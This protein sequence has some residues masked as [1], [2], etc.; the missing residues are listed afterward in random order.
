MRFV[1]EE[2]LPRGYTRLEY[3]ES[4]GT[5]FIDTGVIGIDNTEFVAAY[6]VQLNENNLGSIAG[7]SDGTNAIDFGKYVFAE[8]LT[9]TVP[10]LSYLTNTWDCT[11]AALGD[12]SPIEVVV[13]F[14]DGSQLAVF[15]EEYTLGV[16][17]FEGTPNV[18]KNI[19]LFKVNNDNTDGFTG[20][21]FYF[22]LYSG[23]DEL[24]RNFIPALRKSDNKPGMYDTITNTFYTNAGINEFLYETPQ[25][26]QVEYI[27]NTKYW[28][29]EYIEADGASYI[30]TGVSLKDIYGFKVKYN[31]NNSETKPILGR[32]D[33]T[34]SYSTYSRPRT[35]LRLRGSEVF[36]NQVEGIDATYM[37]V[38]FSLIKDKYVSSLGFS[39]TV[40]EG[41]AANSDLT[42]CLLG[43]PDWRYSTAKLYQCKLYGQNGNMLRNFI[44]AISKADNSIGLYDKVTGNFYTNS[45][46]G[47]FKTGRMVGTIPG[48]YEELE[49]IESTGTQFIDTGYIP[50][51]DTRVVTEHYYTKIPNTKGFVYGAGE[52]ATSKAFELYTWLLPWNSPYNNYNMS[53]NP[54]SESYYTSGK[55]KVDKNKNA[56][57]II[58]SDGTIQST[59]TSYNTF[60]APYTMYLFAIHRPSSAFNSDC[61]RLCKCTIWENDVLIHDFVPCYKKVNN[62]AGMYDR[63]TRSFFGNA[64]TGN[65]IKGMKKDLRNR[66]Q[67]LAMSE[68][69]AKVDGYRRIDY[70]ENTGKTQ[71]IDTGFVANSGSRIETK[72]TPLES[73]NDG[74]AIGSFETD[75]R[76]YIAYQYPTNSWGGGYGNYFAGT[77]TIAMNQE[78]SLVCEFSDKQVITVDGIKVLEQGNSS[79]L[80]IATKSLYLFGRHNNDDGYVNAFSCRLGETKFYQD[81]VLVKDFIPVLDNSDIP[82]MYEAVSKTLYY[83]QGTGNF[84]YGDILIR[85]ATRY[86]CSGIQR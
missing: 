18:N 72:I 35:Y 50:N 23:E 28:Q 82:C 10:Q 62:E 30:D 68:E 40:A 3:L 58:Y 39:G 17:Y 25:E 53:I 52:S 74:W 11:G 33:A 19:Y 81:N 7:V 73:L 1:T 69:I 59:Q 43:V 64:G 22:Q 54:P 71:Y 75:C 46:T 34:L 41:Y 13:Y 48:I 51:Q 63:I 42:A 12:V 27:N 20:K 44:P 36:A 83:N 67:R 2:L 9:I 76:R 85:T 14:R 15:D 79:P 21:I 38:E 6:K 61:L 45:G 78:V 77:S 37:D 47:K 60:S 24:I 5:Q 31:G 49:Y 55:I 80:N 29:V 65:F 70:L 57:Q 16:K 56:I 84:S 32:S 8:G 4:T 26:E 66:I 86:L